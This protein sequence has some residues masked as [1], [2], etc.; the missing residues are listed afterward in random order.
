MIAKLYGQEKNLTISSIARL[1]LFLHGAEDFHIERGDTLGLPAFYSGN[2]LSTF[3]C[4]IANAP[5][6]LEKWGDEI[7]IN[8]PLE[9]TL[10]GRHQTSP[11]TSPG[12][13]MIK[14]M[15]RKTGRMTIVLP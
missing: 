12:Q 11:A 9:E 10:P 15:S 13:H 3:D 1:N 14:S 2:S 6:F 7:W 5:F 8:D 4:V